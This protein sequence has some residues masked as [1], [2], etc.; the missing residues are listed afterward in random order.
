MYI[1]INGA[2]SKSRLGLLTG[3]R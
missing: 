2:C 3:T 1:T